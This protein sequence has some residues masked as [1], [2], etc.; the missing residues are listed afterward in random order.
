MPQSQEQ[1]VQKMIDAGE[2][3]DNIAT[4][5]R[6]FKSSKT[7][8]PK[9]DFSNVKS[10][11]STDKSE[12]TSYQYTPP[13][14]S[15]MSDKPVDEPEPYTYWGGFFKGLKDY[16]SEITSGIKPALESGAVPQTA[17]DML[18]LI[19]PA[20]LPHI[21]RGNLGKIGK[22][23]AGTEREVP[24]VEKAIQA[25]EPLSESLIPRESGLSKIENSIIKEPEILS[26][27][28]YTHMGDPNTG[29]QFGNTKRITPLE[30]DPEWRASMRE[31]WGDMSKDEIN[32]Y[33]ELKSN[34]NGPLDKI[35]PEMHNEFVALQERRPGVAQPDQYLLKQQAE[36]IR[37]ENIKRSELGAA[38]KSFDPASIGFEPKPRQNLMSETGAIGDLSQTPS[39]KLRYRLDRETG[40]GIPIDKAGIQ[41]GP[42]QFAGKEL[43][44]EL[45]EMSKYNQAGKMANEAQKKNLWGE[46]RDAQRALLTSL[47]LSA[48]GRQGKPLLL[49]KAYWTSI[50]DMAKA[51][52]S[53]RASDLI[54]ESIQSMPIFQKPKLAN[55]KFGKSIAER[56]GIDMGKAEQ[57]QSNIAERI[58][59]GVKR[60]SRAYDAFLS[61]LRADH[62]NTMVKDAREMGMNPDK[63]DLVLQQ[64]GSFINDATGKGSLGKLER[65]APILNETFFA[66]RLM[67]SR[68][69]MYKRWLDPRTYSNANP[70]VR[71][72]AIKSLL[73]T[74]GFGAAVGELAR[75]GGAQ[76]SND[77]NSSDFRKIKIGNT[78]IDP[79][80]GFQQ[81]AV[82][83]SR[84]ISGETANRKNPNK[85]FDLTSGKFGMPSR[86]SVASQFFQNKLAPIPSFVWSWMEGK[87]W[88]GQPF[89]AKKAL[90]DR[91]IPIVIQDLTE[92]AKED[93]KLLPLG[94]L[95]ILGEGLQTYG[96]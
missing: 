79:F 96:R 32:R 18:G 38:D 90:L 37:L 92:L 13:S 47:D 39:E 35:T 88:D 65:M 64:I 40:A 75:L 80:S 58:V 91:T 82:G 41:T 11:S 57:F 43:A 49:T 76:V 60:S 67:A 28:Q 15:S 20:E 44:P 55:G 94:I 22:S 4:V 16:G 52:G 46:V 21:A 51:W 2:S 9:Q 74:V 6:H 93:P 70:V 59:P 78:R 81:Y 77:S 83:A 89:D 85:P 73:S 61:K 84:L 63:S 86:A 5:I 53:Q 24:V 66:P 8:E 25:S 50:D 26:P 95:P 19:I 34:M 31:L 36:Q 1:I 12:L 30:A 87:D 56:A 33:N 10:G 62:L 45:A 72:Q 14:E 3:E 17:G 48:L 29:S 23:V 42:A 54:H 71:K 69:N 7:E 27:D 68:V